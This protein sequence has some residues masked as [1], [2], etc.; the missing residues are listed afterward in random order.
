LCDTGAKSSIN[1]IFMIKCCVMIRLKKLR[2]TVKYSAVRYSTYSLEAIR[3]LCP[4]LIDCGSI[5]SL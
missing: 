1:K 3:T 2:S 4:L 5:T